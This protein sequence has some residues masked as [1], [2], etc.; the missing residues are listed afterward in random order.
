MRPITS[1]DVPWVCELMARRRERYAEYSPVFWHPAD[2][3]VERHR[4]YVEYCVADGKF[5]ALRSDNGFVLG[6]LRDDGDCS[7]ED[8]AVTDDALW[9]TEGRA[10]LS[11]AWDEARG[12][13]ATRCRVV[14]ARRDTAL[15][16]MLESC[17]LA[18]VEAWWVQPSGMPA[19]EPPV[20]GPVEAEGVQAL[21]IAAPP[22]YDLGGPVLLVQHLDRPGLA[23]GLLALARARGA[24][25][26]VAPA[27]V[28]ARSLNDALAVAGFE[29]TTEFFAGRPFAA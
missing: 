28:G 25:L 8:F 5:V 4:P 12:R 9:A 18:A 3:A 23:A 11:A 7:I 14:T 16:E 10:L 20:Y 1:R 19:A 24:A 22:V 15:V 17:G 6:E 27:P 26:V 29:E 13:G 2:D 21:Q